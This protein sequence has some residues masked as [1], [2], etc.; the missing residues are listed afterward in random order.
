MILKRQDFI[1][2]VSSMVMSTPPNYKEI[3]GINIGSKLMPTVTE[4]YELELGASITPTIAP[5]LLPKDIDFF[6]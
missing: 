2:K 3:I 4:I 1:D 6:S 5:L